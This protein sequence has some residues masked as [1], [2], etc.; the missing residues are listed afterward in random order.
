MKCNRVG[1]ISIRIF[2]FIL[3]SFNNEIGIPLTILKDESLKKENDILVIRNLLEL[4]ICMKEKRFDETFRYAFTSVSRSFLYPTSDREIYE[5]FVKDSFLTSPL[6]Q[7]CLPFLSIMDSMS[8]SSFFLTLLE[9]F[10]Y[11]EKLFTIGNI[12]Y[13]RTRV[14]YLYQLC[15]QYEETGKTI[16]DFHEY[17]K[18]ILD[19]DYDLDFS[20]LYNTKSEL[21]KLAQCFSSFAHRLQPK[22][23]L[24]GTEIAVNPDYH[25]QVVEKKMIKKSF[26]NFEDVIPF[27]TDLYKGYHRTI[28]KAKIKA[29]GV[30]EC[31]L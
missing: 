11:E 4:I 6:C 10:H 5:Y 3:C 16:Y 22:D 15:R 24:N 26:E 17:L 2:C 27:I 1:C 23:E 8:I 13:F 28:K 12:H 7:E 19:G 20:K 9:H 21:A 29:I 25:I 18:E 31:S 30:I 14:E